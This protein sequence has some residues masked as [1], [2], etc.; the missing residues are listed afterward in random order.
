MSAVR[1]VCN[2]RKANPNETTLRNI[3]AYLAGSSVRPIHCGICPES[4]KMTS[5]SAT[6]S[7]MLPKR[8]IVCVLFAWLFCLAPMHCE[9]MLAPDCAKAWSAVNR[10]PRIGSM[11]PTPAAAVSEVRERNQLSIM[12]WIMPTANVRIS[13]QERLIRERSLTS[14]WGPRMAQF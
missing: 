14:F 11:A 2:A 10:A 9:T 5:V 13:G 8:T 7:K 4:G 3:I 6:P 1:M 12:G